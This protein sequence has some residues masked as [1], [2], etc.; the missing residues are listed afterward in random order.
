MIIALPASTWADEAAVRNLDSKNKAPASKQG[1]IMLPQV[2]EGI[3]ML[4]QNTE[5]CTAEIEGALRYNSAHKIPET[6][7]SLGWRAWGEVE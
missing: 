2:G 6:C 7:T 1:S 5:P 3:L 4:P